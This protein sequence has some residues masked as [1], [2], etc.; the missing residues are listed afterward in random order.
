[1]RYRNK[2]MSELADKIDSLPIC[3]RLV[4]GT[5]SAAGEPLVMLSSVTAWQACRE[6]KKVIGLIH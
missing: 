1:M 3:K 2:V 4:H 5:D 6:R